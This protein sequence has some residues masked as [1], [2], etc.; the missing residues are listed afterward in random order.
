MIQTCHILST[1]NRLFKRGCYNRSIIQQD[2]PEYI[3]NSRKGGYHLKGIVSSFITVSVFVSFYYF[4]KMSL[5]SISLNV[6]YKFSIIKSPW[7]IS[8]IFIRKSRHTIKINKSR[9]L[10]CQHQSPS[11]TSGLWM[12]QG[13]QTSYR[14]ACNELW[15]VGT[16]L[17]LTFTVTRLLAALTWTPSPPHYIKTH[18]STL[19]Q[20]N[21][22]FFLLPEL[23]KLLY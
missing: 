8:P 4:P 6:L 1:I 5:Y 7:I 23:T 17:S 18:S 19:T 14:P 9:H 10:S 15:F 12:N 13:I 21:A 2:S 3:I 11:R 22:L 20:S 16:T